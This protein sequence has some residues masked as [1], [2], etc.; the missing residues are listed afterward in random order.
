ML[1]L[2]PKSAHNVYQGQ[3]LTFS[4][5]IDQICQDIH[6]ATK[7]LGTDEKALN[8]AL[9]P[10][11]ADT[12][13]QIAVR[14]KQLFNE[15]LKDLVK[16]EAGGHYGKLLAAISVPLP[17]MEADIVRLATKGA[18]TSE[19]LIYPV[20]VGRTND[21]INILKKTY[22]DLYNEDVGVLMNSELGGDFK[23]IIMASI[24]AQLIPFNASFHTAAKADEDAE[25]LYK[26]GEGKF[27][28]DEE[29]FIKILVSN[30]PEHL[31]NVNTIY[32]KK[33]NNTIIRAV[34][35]EFTRH[36]EKALLFLVRMILE[37]LD[38]LAELF[39]STMKGFGTDEEGLTAAVVRY[40]IVLPQIKEAYKKKYGK[41]LR[42]RIH[43]EVSGDY[44]ALLLSVFD[45]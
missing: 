10:K 14:Y 28:T 43:G 8:A 39:E 3:N 18:G 30:P 24:Q 21:E 27:G 7:G 31:R 4:P 44:R 19:D 35:K 17:E 25:K 37:P 9:G 20:L 15:S 5:E 6:A 42:D 12:R 2:Y 23:K 26:A 36:A 22:F 32:T 38:M 33:Y 45:N 41:E 40:H 16:S 1:N 29:S 11:S 13:Y 34:E